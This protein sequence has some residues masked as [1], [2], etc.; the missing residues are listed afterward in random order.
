MR[1]RMRG[2]S[3]SGLSQKLGNGKLTELEN[4]LKTG[5]QCL[6]EKEVVYVH[7]R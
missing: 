7:R 6:S 5:V 2:E 1:L 4:I 3:W